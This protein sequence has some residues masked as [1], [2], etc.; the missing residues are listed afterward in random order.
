MLTIFNCMLGEWSEEAPALMPAQNTNYPVES[1][2]LSLVWSLRATLTGDYRPLF[3]KFLHDLF[4]GNDEIFPMPK[5][6]LSKQCSLMLKLS[7]TFVTSKRAQAAEGFGLEFSSRKSLPPHQF[8]FKC[9][10]RRLLIKTN[11]RW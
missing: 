10:C 3:D 4:A 11:R 2:L 5:S 8:M 9:F 1:F 6:S 7:M